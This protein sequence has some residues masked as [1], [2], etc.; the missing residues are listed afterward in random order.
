MEVWHG[1]ERQQGKA[2]G[3]GTWRV[4]EWSAEIQP[5]AS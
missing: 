2:M 4:R 1:E 5:K 3:V